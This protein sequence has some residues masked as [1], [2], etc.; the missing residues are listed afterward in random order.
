MPP[1]WKTWPFLP[2]MAAGKSSS[3]IAFDAFHSFGYTTPTLAKST[4]NKLCYFARALCT[5]KNAPA[6]ENVLCKSIRVVE[7]SEE[8]IQPNTSK[9]T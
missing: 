7:K 1:V 8:M 9:V 6:R 3:V 4:L 5:F 2:T